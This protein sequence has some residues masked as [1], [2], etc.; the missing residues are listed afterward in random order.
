[1]AAKKTKRK[2]S[3]KQIAAQKRFAK[4]AKSGALAKARKTRAGNPKGKHLAGATKKEQ[5]QY[6][7]ILASAK[8]GHRYKGRE[9]EV[10][11]RTV[12]ARNTSLNDQE[13][14]VLRA[15]QH[16]DPQF[17]TGALVSIRDL[18]HALPYPKYVSKRLLLDLA[19]K[20]VV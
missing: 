9:K 8:P 18:L 12:R 5:R 4:M 11:A 7:H 13:I 20:G 15:A 6:E 17:R 19:N 10:A 14:T 3:P 16:V 1:M 2:F